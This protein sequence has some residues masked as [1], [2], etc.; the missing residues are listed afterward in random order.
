MITAPLSSPVAPHGPRPLGVYIHFPW[1]LSKCPYCDF[2]SIAEPSP[3]HRDYADAVLAELAARLPQLEGPVEVKTVFFGGGTPSLWE[4]VQLARVL[5]GVLSALPVAPDCEITVECN[6]SSLDRASAE[7]LR[8]AG[9]TRLSI[10]VQ[11]L[12][13]ERLSFLGR[14]HDPQGARRALTAAYDAGFPHLS[15]DL[16]FGLP[17]QPWQEAVEDVQELLTLGVDHVSAYALTIEPGTRFGTLARQG[18]LPLA[19]EDD[20]AVAFLA[21]HEALAER[22]MAHYEISN[23]ARPGCEARHNLGYWRGQDYLGLGCGAWGTVT[24]SGGVLR[25]RNTPAPARYLAAS[26]ADWT[27]PAMREGRPDGLVTEAEWLDGETRLLER[28]MLGLRVLGG[29]DLQE[30]AT[31]LGVTGWTPR[32]RRAAER[33]RQSGRLLV[34][35]DRLAIAPQAWIMAD[36]IIADLA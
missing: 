34:D 3:P 6:P 31:R 16:I 9:V 11:S 32:R 12:R 21:L 15:G 2:L 13:Q 17:G 7:A 19:V 22:G 27:E 28:L 8:R 4:P 30:E 26:A 10:G 33:H 35:G 29:L 18:R 1:C 5:S 20:V 36:G 14:R 25:Y 24:T 23:Y